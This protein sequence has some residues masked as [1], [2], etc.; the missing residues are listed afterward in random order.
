MQFAKHNR[1][2]AIK[3]GFASGLT[4]DPDIINRSYDLFSPGYATD[5]SVAYDGIQ[6]MLDEDIDA[7]DSSIRSLR[8]DRVI[9]DRLLKQAQAG[10]A[11]PREN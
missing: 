10:I 11:P 5:L 6:I 1:Q 9:N 7:T 8:L 3:I 2:E 4:G